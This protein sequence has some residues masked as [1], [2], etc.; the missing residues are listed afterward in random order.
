METIDFGNN[1]LWNILFV[2]EPFSDTSIIVRLYARQ[3]VDL[4]V[5]HIMSFFLGLLLGA[6]VLWEFIYVK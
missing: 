5:E 2:I 6:L 1:N 3:K 4:S